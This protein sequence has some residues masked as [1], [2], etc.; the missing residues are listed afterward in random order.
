MDLYALQLSPR[1]K[2]DDKRVDYAKKIKEHLL[3]KEEV[4]A[5]FKKD[6]V[7]TQQ[8]LKPSFAV[9]KK[10]EKHSEKKSKA[11]TPKSPFS[12]NSISYKKA[13]AEF[14]KEKTQKIF[15][16]IKKDALTESIA[17]KSEEQKT[18]QIDAL[19]Q[20]N[21]KHKQ[22]VSEPQIENGGKEKEAERTIKKSEQ[23]KEISK[24]FLQE[25]ENIQV[26]QSRK[27][28]LLNEDEEKIIDKLVEAA[29]TDDQKKISI[30]LE[31]IIAYRAE[32]A[33]R[34]K[35][36]CQFNIE[37]KNRLISGI[38]AM[39]AH[40]GSRSVIHV[41][42]LL[43]EL[44]IDLEEHDLVVLPFDFLQSEEM[45][46]TVEKYLIWC[47]KEYASVPGVLQKKIL[48]FVKSGIFSFVEIPA[49]NKLQQEIFSD[50]L[51]FVKN[52]VKNPREIEH[53]ICE[54]ALVGFISNQEFKKT[55]PVREIIKRF[56]LTIVGSEKNSTKEIN[57]KL[58][59]Y[60]QV[61]LITNQE[62]Q[63]DER[64]QKAVEKYLVKFSKENKKHPRKI[65][66]RIKEYFDIGLIDK[67]TRDK[68]LKI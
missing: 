59:E 68:F 24:V 35:Q 23:Q 56:L 57:K 41:M 27:E 26:V 11:K 45:K 42:Q 29:R 17:K 16:E 3:T 8:E 61:G 60:E 12:A 54:Y 67:Q 43:D 18:P 30:A 48:C 52:N 51:Q 36:E 38:P 19:A 2:K 65:A 14:K 63:S 64:I 47:A 34:Y 31:A 39:I 9:D 13:L 53:K 25:K 62:L 55:L 15:S 28:N 44:S 33:E 46:E 21:A 22:K 37:L 1:K 50:L 4:I 7:K 66:Q 5:S 20:W 10:K 58:L 32:N 40:K 6:E 49:M